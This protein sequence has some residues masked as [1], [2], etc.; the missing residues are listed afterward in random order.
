MPPQGVQDRG[1][2]G[3]CGRWW[4]L[5]ANGTL[6]AHKTKAGRECRGTWEQ[7]RER[8]EYIPG[9]GYAIV[10]DGLHT[11]VKNPSTG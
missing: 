6:R 7:P 4:A 5:R 10:P 9:T 1:L 11:E 3:S 2:C 8:R